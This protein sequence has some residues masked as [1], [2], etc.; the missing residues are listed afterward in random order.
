MCPQS[1]NL[2]VD[3]THA[4][5]PSRRRVLGA[6]AVAL[7]GA[8]TGLWI[9]DRSRDPQ[10]TSLTGAIATRE[11]ARSRTGRVVHRQ[12]RAS[13]R[14]IDLGGQLVSTWAFADQ[15]PGSEI[16]VNVGDELRVDL[17]NDLPRPTSVH[18]HGLALRNDM[19]GVPSVTMAPVAAGDSFAY[20]FVVPDA[21]T[22]WFHPH[23]GVQLDTGLYAPLI[24]E[25][26]DEDA[27][28]EAD[29]T[30]VL[31]D[32]T[33]GLGDTPDDI[34]ARSRADG[35]RMTSSTMGSESPP[36]MEGMEGMAGMDAS[37]ATTTGSTSG[38]V[39]ATQPLGS[40]TGDVSYA[41]HL[42]N[43]RLPS[44]PF[45]VSSRVGQRL[46]VRLINAGADT[47]YRV[48]IGGHR[49]TVT[50]S[51]GFPVEPVTVDAVMLGMGERYDLLVEAGDGVFPI[52][53]VAEGKDDP[54]A[55]AL[56]RTASGSTPPPQVRPA[57]LTG[58]LLSYAD[59]QP[60]QAVTL[61]TDT[62]DR[63][64]QVRLQMVDGGRAW[65]LNGRAYPDYAA[66]PVSKGE[67]VR[68][69]LINETMMFHPMHLHGHTFALS[70]VNGV[71]ARGPRKDTVNVLPM[72]SVSID[73]DADNP[74]QW[75]LHC[76]NAYHGEQGMMTVM[77]YEV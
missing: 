11:A 21:G 16:R 52:V 36:G 34:L 20:S 74:G 14:T 47:A 3:E 37:G 26:P 62:P 73:L 12:L 35:M 23:V 61:R 22:Y 10:P 4:K 24:V 29:V 55:L 40:D 76:H 18:W 28:Y 19:D 68:L 70:A 2:E 38:V 44:D 6:G 49:L 75:L 13:P 71:A 51:D 27:P 60:T 46:R 15:V 7:V 33:D 59:L 58:R 63:E 57:E 77:S 5:K 48:A 31:D 25:D 8:G 39:N 1:E 30:L 32:W 43:G 67:R 72:Q 53:A 54:S 64:M 65:T 45:V 66:L 9:A 17:L 69:N 50:H 42:I 56:L 41:A